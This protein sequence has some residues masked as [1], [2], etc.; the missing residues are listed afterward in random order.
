M[1]EEMGPY[2]REDVNMQ[3]QKGV[4]SKIICKF[5]N[6]TIKKKIGVDPKI[7]ILDLQ[8]RSICDTYSVVVCATA[9]VKKA[10]VESI[11]FGK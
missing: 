8:I 10:D 1:D 9:N 6:A 2:N 4:I 11:I 7:D 5:L 3:L